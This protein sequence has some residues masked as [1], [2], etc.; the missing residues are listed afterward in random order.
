MGSCWA[1]G[2]GSREQ[3]GERMNRPSAQQTVRIGRADGSR[4]SDVHAQARSAL[5]HTPF[6][7]PTTILNQDQIAFTHTCVMSTPRLA[8]WAATLG[9]W[10]STAARGL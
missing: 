7:Q 5:S 1:G 6:T 4:G 2:V 10:S 8:Q 3:G 9:K